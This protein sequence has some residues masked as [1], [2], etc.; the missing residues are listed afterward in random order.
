MTIIVTGGS[1]FIGTNLIDYYLKKKYKIFNF[2]IN[3]PKNKKHEKYWYKVNLLNYSAFRKNLLKLKPRYIIHLAAKTDL[4]G[5]RLDD[6]NV[7]IK[8]VKNIIKFCTKHNNIKRVL[9]ASTMLVNQTG[10]NPKS[11]LNYNA[12]TYYGHSKIIGENIILKSTDLLTD[13]C[14]IRPTSIWGEWFDEPYRNFFNY[15]MSERYFHPGNLSSKK[16]FGYVGNAVYQID[17]ILFASKK[18]IRS[19][20]FYIGDKPPVNISKWA[21]EIALLSNVR[22]PKKIPFFMFKLLAI[23]GDLIIKLGIKFPMSSYRLKNMT[24]NQVYNLRDTYDICGKPPF[25]RK[26]AIKNTLNWICQQKYML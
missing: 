18:K 17:K 1:G 6:Y 13:F 11:I 16:T 22:K 24:T 12:N 15:V 21:D 14:I 3:P 7:N 20:I 2:D 5:E 26:I 8:S 9:F 25:D 4:N 23:F 19:K 10:H